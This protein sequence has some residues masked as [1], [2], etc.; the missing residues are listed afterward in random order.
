MK[1]KL[2]YFFNFVKNNPAHF[3]PLDP[4]IAKL[5]D[6]NISSC[7]CATPKGTLTTAFEQFEKVLCIE[8]CR[9]KILDKSKDL[10]DDS[11]QIEDFSVNTCSENFQNK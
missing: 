10:L 3:S 4:E 2:D 7:N 8:T 5:Y 11:I 9:N 1:I 6:L